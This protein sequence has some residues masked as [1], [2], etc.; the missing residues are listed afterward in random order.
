V[1][2]IQLAIYI[3]NDCSSMAARQ[4]KLWSFWAVIT[5]VYGTVAILAWI[6][7]KTATDRK[8]PKEWW[9]DKS[10]PLEP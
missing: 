7:H 6:G 4:S 3:G 9:H 5:I 2:L 1:P 8:P 10:S